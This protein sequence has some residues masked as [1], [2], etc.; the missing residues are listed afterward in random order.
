M[1]RSIVRQLKNLLIGSDLEQLQ[2]F[3]FLSDHVGREGKILDVGCGFGRNLRFL[4]DAK[5]SI[6]GVEANQ[7][8]VRI[9]QEKGLPCYSPDSPEVCSSRFDAIL[10]SHIVEHFSP[11]ALRD[12]L[13]SYLALLKPGGKI[14]IATPLMSDY[15]YDDFDHVRPYHP[16]SFLLLMGSDSQ[17]QMQYH[18]QWKI[19]LLDVWFRPCPWQKSHARGRYVAG[20]ERKIYSIFNLALLLIYRMSFRKLGRVDGWVGVFKLH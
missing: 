17:S 2:I 8:I 5:F 19:R 14:L 11:E 10:F 7:N 1:K 9:N 6:I 12:F 15:F 18:S 4:R 20:L 16:E 13:N 3:Q